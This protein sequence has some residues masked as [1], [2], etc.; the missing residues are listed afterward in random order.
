MLADKFGVSH[1]TASRIVRRL[2][3]KVSEVLSANRFN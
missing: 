1:V 2:D 3:R